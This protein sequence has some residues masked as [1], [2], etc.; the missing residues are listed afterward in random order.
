MFK[1][2]GAQLKLLLHALVIKSLKSKLYQLA[3]LNNGMLKT[4]MIGEPIME[5]ML[6]IKELLI[7]LRGI[8]T[9]KPLLQIHLIIGVLIII[10]ILL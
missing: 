1:E 6:P 8:V 3:L 10:V 7:N 5:T 9:T 4:F 2:F